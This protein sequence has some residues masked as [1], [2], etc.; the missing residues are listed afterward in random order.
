MSRAP[1]DL[2]RFPPIP[3][4][5]ASTESLIIVS[6]ALKEAVELLTGQRAR[7]NMGV[8]AVTW[9]DL[10]FR[11]ME[12]TSVASAKLAGSAGGIT[13]IDRSTDSG[14]SGSS[15]S[16]G[17]PGPIGAT[18]PAGPT[19]AT[20]LTGSTGATG[21]TGP[22][23][24]P[25]AV[26]PDG[27]TGPVGPG[28]P[29]GG[30]VGQFLK[31]TSTPVDYATAWTTLLVTDVASL[32]GFLDARELI[33]NKSDNILLGSSVDLYPTQHAV[34]TYVDNSFAANDAM[35]FKGTISASSNPNY[36]AA[37]AGHTYRITSAGKI[38]GASGVNVEVGDLIICIVDGSAAGTQAAVG[39]NWS[40]A[41]GNIDGAVIGPAA[42]VTDGNPVLWDG[43][44]GRLI[45]Q[46]TFAAFKASLAIAA[47][48]VSGLGY[49]ATG[50]DAAN[51]TGTVAS[52]RIV[53]SYTGFTSITMTSPLNMAA[54]TI[55]SATAVYQVLA[56]TIAGS[57]T[58]FVGF[59]AASAFNSAR[60]AFVAIYGV[61]NG[62]LPGDIRL[63]TGGAGRV[64]VNGTPITA[65]VTST[66]AANLTG[67]VA[68]ARLATNSV[69]LSKLVNASATAH[70]LMRTTAGAGA[71]EDG[72]AAQAKTALAIASGDV[73]GLG[74]F[75]TGT[76][77]ANLTGT[78]ADARHAVNSIALTKLVNAS[79]TS[80]MLGRVTAGSGAWEEL[81]AA[82][83]ISVMGLGTAALKNTSTTGNNVP[84]LDGANT[85]SARQ[86]GR[87]D[88]NGSATFPL[89]LLN[90][91]GSL[92]DT[93]VGID[94][95]PS[96]NGVGVRSAQ[97]I[98]TLPVGG[99]NQVNLQFLT[100]AA[101]IAPALRA[102]IGSLGLFMA[103]TTGQGAGTIN[104]TELYRNGVSLAT[105]FALYAT[106][107]GA[108]FS[109]D[110]L[111]S[112]ATAKIQGSS[113]ATASLRIGNT[114]ADAADSGDLQL[115]GGGNNS[116]SNRGSYFNL[117]GNE[118][119]S[120]PGNA[121][122]VAGLTGFI[123]IG[124]VV[125]SHQTLS[126]DAAFTL[127]PSTSPRYTL[128]TGTLTTARALTLS[129]S[130]ATKGS[131]FRVT[132]TGGGAFNITNALKN[133][134]TNQW[135]EFVFDG[136]AWYLSA[137]GSL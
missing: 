28:V 29:G 46:T 50:T 114:T 19:G 51:L 71:W 94:F 40:I 34:K 13:G 104:A 63:V 1:L 90:A 95:D 10:K 55:A 41:Q 105:T 127:T 38:G 119:P 21:P 107:T 60:S 70:F 133:I 42:V 67:T 12:L 101:G 73:S 97:I 108:T 17:I 109:G 111:F 89:A 74:Y 8:A 120:Q 77:A 4:P 69:S 54:H 118:H 130:G 117:Y 39:A 45:K 78:I 7:G 66:D 134:A 26:G 135:A 72:T 92:I 121:I 102:T 132:R 99:S 2:R 129:T 83:A 88:A 123:R 93:G 115:Y 91:G 32:P 98:A 52:A 18:G 27:A 86:I 59:S 137:F 68:D 85:W 62:S 81:T 49:F 76:D 11:G 122:L 64:T 113:G 106:L 56:T 100:S 47:G 23:G 44:S 37:D 82:Q 79:A 126:T 131:S 84:L 96:G 58:G 5:Q 116:D 6:R 3:E 61:D 43:T 103:G 53:G 65:F 80:K 124:S 24:S 35:I 9:D 36:P 57:D 20:G 128:H 75:A 33:A 25:G 112:A 136:S 87:I 30:L 48:D 125:Y 22:A 110:L 16:F 14:G 31:K 15:G